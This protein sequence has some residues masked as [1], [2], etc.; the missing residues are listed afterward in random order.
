[1]TGKDVELLAHYQPPGELEP[2][3]RL[4]SDAANGE[5][6]YFARQDGVEAAWKIVDPVVGDAVPVEFYEPGTW[7][8][9]SSERI[10]APQDCWHQPSAIL[11]A[12][13]VAAAA[14]VGA[15]A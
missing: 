1:M 3:E 8:P 12:E 10:I 11:D 14:A 5:T 9:P 13:T 7:G 2:Y 6:A 15:K 4:L